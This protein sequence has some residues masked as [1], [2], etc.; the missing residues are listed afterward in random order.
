MK[1]RP[2]KVFLALMVLTMSTACR[3]TKFGDVTASQ[4]FSDSK[5]ARLVDA[6]SRGDIAEMD[7]LIEQG[8]DVNMVGRD[9]VTP[10]IWVMAQRNREGAERLLKAGANPNAK[11]I[12]HQSAMSLAT[13]GNQPRMLE[14]LLQHGGDPNL[15]GP[16]DDPLLNI[17]ALKQKDEQLRI[18][19][20]HGA[21]I[22]S[23]KRGETAAV[24]AAAM[25]RFDEVVFLL[26]KGLTYNLNGL[27]RTVA[28][29][30]VPPQ[31]KQHIAKEK[32]IEMLKAKGIQF[33]P[34]SKRMAQ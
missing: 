29:R 11:M 19:L 1:H 31:S 22:N 12:R 17:A 23:N 15:E 8:A 4:A 7:A 26:E 10:L 18:L 14:L 13:G 9:G 33:P 6:G 34:P 32:V 21:D 28:V 3:E 20:K 30:H 24:V 2:I 25:G 5:V 27:A 16:D